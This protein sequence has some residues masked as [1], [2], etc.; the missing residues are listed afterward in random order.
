ML[1]VPRYDGRWFEFGSRDLTSKQF[2]RRSGRKRDSV[3][4]PMRWSAVCGVRPNR[5]RNSVGIDSGLVKPLQGPLKVFDPLVDPGVHALGSRH[6]WPRWNEI[7]GR[8]IRAE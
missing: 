3:R 6:S 1:R 4:A 7:V 2:E 8:R 5:N